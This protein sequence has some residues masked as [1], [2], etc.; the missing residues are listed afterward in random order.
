MGLSA[1]AYVELTWTRAFGANVKCSE[2]SCIYVAEHFE[3]LRTSKFFICVPRIQMSLVER[4]FMR[5]ASFKLSSNLTLAAT[6]NII[7]TLSMM[8]LLSTGGKPKP[9]SLQSPVTGMSFSRALGLLSLNVSKS[10]LRMQESS[11]YYHFIRYAFY[12]W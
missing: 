3:R 4:K 9:S 6:W 11:F 10:C 2:Y 8:I 5:I 1:C 12:S 7:D